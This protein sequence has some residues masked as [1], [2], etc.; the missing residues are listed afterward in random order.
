MQVKAKVSQLCLPSSNL[1][2]QVVCEAEVHLYLLGLARYRYLPKSAQLKIAVFCYHRGKCVAMWAR[3]RQQLRT[4]TNHTDEKELSFTP[5]H[6]Q[7]PLCFQDS[8]LLCWIMWY[9]TAALTPASTKTGLTC[10]KGRI[11]HR[12]GDRAATFP[13]LLGH[14]ATATCSWI[15]TKA[16][17]RT[18]RVM[19]YKEDRTRWQWRWA[20]VTRSKRTLGSS[21]CLFQSHFKV[22]TKADS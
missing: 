4:E 18:G 20:L 1:Y 3:G 5:L 19:S 12:P 21:I 8:V 10:L 13:N 22:Y 15:K 11:S 14:G 16:G 7:S 9:P 6:P 17:V 2:C